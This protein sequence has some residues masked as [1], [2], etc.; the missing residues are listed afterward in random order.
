VGGLLQ[1]LRRASPRGAM[2][3][4]LVLD[5]VAA[6][7]TAVAASRLDSLPPFIPRQRNGCNHGIESCAEFREA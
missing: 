3:T 1:I 4:V 5:A 7:G 2:N 6:D